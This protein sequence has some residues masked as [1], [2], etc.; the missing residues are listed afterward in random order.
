MA[1]S[2]S[3]VRDVSAA[4]GPGGGGS[5]GGGGNSGPG[6]G[7]SGGS[8]GGGNSGPG[9]GGKNGGGGGSKGGGRW[10]NTVWASCEVSGAGERSKISAGIVG[11]KGKY[12]ARV[13]NANRVKIDSK[14]KTAVSRRTEVEFEFDSDPSDISQGA[15]A[16]P[17][18]FIVNG[19]V[20]I[21]VRNA[22]TKV[23][24]GAVRVT[25]ANR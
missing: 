3:A 16:I 5:G 20:H 21:Y 22:K 11:N 23:N 12:F 2:L 17:P 15:T 19:Y 8:G 1:L 14:A 7:G 18:N 24:V 10:G 9:G 4:S 25:C 6:S 13:V